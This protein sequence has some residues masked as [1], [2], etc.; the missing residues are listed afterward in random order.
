[1]IETYSI[2]A[3]DRRRRMRLSISAAMGGTGIVIGHRMED[4]AGAVDAGSSYIFQFGD[5]DLRCRSFTCIA[6][7]DGW[8]L[9]SKRLAE[10]E[11]LLIPPR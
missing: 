11:E 3:A 9:E 5:V 6:A 10:R 7:Q 8:I 1:M 2:T 4:P